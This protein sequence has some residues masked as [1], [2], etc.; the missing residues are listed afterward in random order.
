MD[1]KW[2]KAWHPTRDT[3]VMV[4]EETGEICNMPD[5]KNDDNILASIM[6]DYCDTI[7]AIVEPRKKV[8]KKAPLEQFNVFEYEL[9]SNHIFLMVQCVG[10]INQ[11]GRFLC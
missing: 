10:R 3:Y 4:N 1:G 5:K 9:R 11:Y 7:K 6:E 2:K 8:P